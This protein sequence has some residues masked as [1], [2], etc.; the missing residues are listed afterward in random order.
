M[1]DL[2]PNWERATLTDLCL[3]ITKADP[4]DLGRESI[5]YIDIGSVD[6]ARHALI[7]VPTIDAVGAPS[8]CRQV[9]QTGD[10]V[11]STVRP[12][13]EKIAYVDATLDGEF[14]S[15][16]F[17]VLRPRPQLEPRYLFHFSVSQQ[18]LDQILPFQK[19]V[20]YPAVLDKEVRA[21]E[22]PLP[23]LAEQRRIVEALD[24][25]LSCLDAAEALLSKATARLVALRMA[26]L[27][28]MLDAEAS[29]RKGW[30]IRSIGEVA[31][32]ANGQTPKGIDAAGT[33]SDG[34]GKLPFYKVGDMNS[35][36]SRTMAGAR[37]YL[38]SEA[39]SALSL[40]SWPTGTVL[41]PKRGGA[42]ATNKKRI[43]GRTACYDLN[44]MG[45]VP[46]EELRGDFLWWA[47]QLVD[48]GALA[49]GSNVPQINTPDIAPVQIPVPPLETQLQIVQ[50]LDAMQDGWSRIENAIRAAA[51]PSMRRSLLG[52]AFSGRL[53][54]QDP[55]D[56]PARVLLERIATERAVHP[57]RRK[58]TRATS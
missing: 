40:R 14:A 26:T 58:P 18:M 9:V 55:D 54:P 20:S 22:I 31:R 33:A 35:T 23:P 11:F 56:E 44:T 13:L 16:G 43:L 1:S 39:V 3:P 29:R 48:L 5:R 36:P 21:T 8:R 52:A 41:L 42:I 24:D 46:G 7:D 34:P 4:V 17:C 27:R 6:G 49:D 12:Y 25:H 19:G 30:P 57:K 47:L 15:T 37:T 2:P 10:T 51:R 28:S 50:Q 32:I 38:D 45:L 53:V